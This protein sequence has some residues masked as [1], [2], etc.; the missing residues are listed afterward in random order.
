MLNSKNRRI[1]LQMIASTMKFL[2]LHFYNGNR[3]GCIPR[4]KALLSNNWTGHPLNNANQVSGLENSRE[5][6]FR[7]APFQKK[8]PR[9][10]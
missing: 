3:I 4:V 9:N 10:Q 7:K 6:L 2:A 5:E 8:K 1:W